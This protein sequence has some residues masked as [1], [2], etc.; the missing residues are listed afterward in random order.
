MKK[1]SEM[2]LI[3]YKILMEAFMEVGRNNL[4]PCGSGNKYKKCCLNKDIENNNKIADKRKLLFSSGDFPNIEEKVKLVEKIIE[5]YEFCDLVV[6]VFCINISLNNRSALENLLA[7]N[8]GLILRESFGTKQIVSYSDFIIFFRKIE[9]I[10]PIT[11][12][13]D[14]T[15]ED[16]GEVKFYWK[17]R[18][19]NLII[20]T[21]HN[22][23][24]GMLQYFPELVKLLRKEDR[25]EELLNYTSSTID[26]FSKENISNGDASVRFLVPTEELF[27]RTQEYFSH[28]LEKYSL[29]NFAGNFD[30]N[31][32]SIEKQH[33]IEKDGKIFPLFNLSILVD[34]YSIW[35][36][37]LDFEQKN[38][39]I[40]STLFQ[41]LHDLCKLDNR[42][43]PQVLFPVSL[44][45][46]GKFASKLPYSFC[47][48]TKKGIILAIN[49]DEYSEEEL[50]HEIEKIGALHVTDCLVIAEVVS[51]RGNGDAIAIRV[52]QNEDVSF[53]FF[54]QF[55][56][57]T[58]HVPHFV[59]RDS[60]YHECS[61]L[62][63]V[64][65]LLFMDDFDELDLYLNYDSEK[66][67]DQMF[68]F[69]GD[70]SQF[71]TWKQQD[72]MFSK[73][74]IKF[75]MIGLEHDI[76]ATYVWEY[77]KKKLQNYPWG[78]DDFMFDFPFCWDIKDNGNGYY[79]YVN[80]IAGGFGGVVKR[81]DNGCTLFFIHNAQFFK[82]IEILE[83]E[84]EGIHFIDDLND[85]KIK[86]C[87]R[88][89]GNSKEMSNK[90]VQ[91]LYI[92]TS[93]AK[94]IDKTRFTE[95]ETRR[96]VYSD[97]T[98]VDHNIIC[99]RYTV[100][101]S[102]LFEDIQKVK[103]R[104]V[105]TRY[106]LELFKPLE[107]ICKADYKALESCLN[108]DIEKKKEVDAF[109][110]SIDYYWSDKSVPYYIHKQR[111]LRVRKDIAKLCYDMGIEQKVYIGKAATNV[112]R[113]M[114]SG[115][116]KIFE[117]GV[118]E[119]NRE[120]LHY[121]TLGT[122]ASSIHAVHIHKKRYNAFEDVEEEVVDE[123]HNKIVSMREEEKRHVRSMQYLIETNLFLKREVSKNCSH[124]DFEYL[125][126]FANWLV[127]FQDSADLCYNSELEFHIEINSEFIVDVIA[128]DGIDVLTQDHEKRIYENNNYTIRGD[129]EDD[130][131]LTAAISAYKKDTNINF[132]NMLS[133]IEYLQLTFI[134]MENIEVIPNV[135]KVKEEEIAK[136]F[137]DFLEASIEF[138]EIRQILDYLIVDEDKLKFW[139]GETTNFLPFNERENRDNRFDVK[140]LTRINNYIIFSPVVLKELHSKWKYGLT[141][142]YLPYEIGLDN[143][144]KELSLWKKR[145]EDLMVF[146]IADIFS[147][148]GYKKYWP[149]VKLHSL[150]KKHKHP[151]QLGDYD[152]LVINDEKAEIWLIES[153]FLNKVGSI[154]EMY[155]QQSNF[156]L[157]HKYDEK[158]L[159]RI[160]YM[161]GHY[162]EILETM[163]I[164][165]SKE[166]S[167]FSYM[168][169]NKILISRYKKIEY[170]I[171]TLSELEKILSER[172]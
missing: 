113:T 78:I 163:Q 59:E 126:A 42:E 89:F 140:P 98:T 29:N 96:Y 125:M 142:F 72:H 149:N 82:G 172:V 19:Y 16:F 31:A 80:K 166:F 75:G 128:E 14:Y 115:L 97:A 24:F 108:S 135:F 79:Q 143:V 9:K 161:K 2:S 46:E 18:T 144:M 124:E 36:K 66:D 103:D 51:R 32:L 153:K 152:L 44:L 127:V 58:E 65:F 147:K 88:I 1:H 133:L 61:A 53:V 50:S 170:P 30:N 3:K 77:Y 55:T 104:T 60:K 70:S 109:T 43:C 34:I 118:A 76:D 157:V 155:M 121:R 101:V 81:F 159:N 100:N 130:K 7:L 94:Q 23:V 40:N 160:N 8:A 13:A 27:I 11:P 119:F 141:D 111:Y 106:F 48:R 138:E 114:Q 57:I 49:K 164:E 87:E 91:I 12:W 6:A 52:P 112:I 83:K 134:D 148:F 10:L 64:Y 93:Y 74:A 139:K 33:F 85:R 129:G 37:D 168:V 45:I 102:N 41:I 69:G 47:A 122:F 158:F 84:F 150:D 107:K 105:E 169:T 154:H 17:E 21:G 162:K 35:I 22:Q 120:D 62:D 39:V 123:V 131:Y 25:F 117:L 171:V 145:Y 15:M 92:P 116:I 71:L 151:Q 165:Y 5:E 132:K 68:G 20:G 110:V 26:F 4:C 137:I 54:N 63:M 95:D 99:I 86:K 146:E 38:T 156:F 28:E 167:I 56:D 90:C 136:G 67:Y 73:G